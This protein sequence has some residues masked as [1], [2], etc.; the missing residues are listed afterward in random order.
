MFTERAGKFSGWKLLFLG[1]FLR[2]IVFNYVYGVAKM[3]FLSKGRKVDLQVLCEELNLEVTPKHKMAELKDMITSSSE[4]DP[5]FTEKFL[6]NIIAQRLEEETRQAAD[7]RE[8][9]RAAE[10]AFELEKLR[11]AAGLPGSAGTQNGYGTENSRAIHDLK[12]LIQKF[13]PKEGDISLWLVLFERQAGHAQ[14]RRK[15]G[16]PSCWGC[17]RTA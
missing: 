7:K 5:E 4:Y 16:Y 6:D 13:D 3:A 11:I 12:R 8:A 15:I 9:E 10:R 2:Y 14:I 1:W 17:C